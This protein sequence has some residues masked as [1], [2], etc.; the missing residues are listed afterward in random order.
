MSSTIASSTAL[1]TT[2][3]H[4]Q[5]LRNAI[6]HDMRLLQNQP[7]L[8]ANAQKALVE[9]ER[10]KDSIDYDL[11]WRAKHN[12]E[13]LLATYAEIPHQVSL[14]ISAAQTRLQ[15]LDDDDDY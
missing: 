3:R 9:I 6:C 1:T 8:I 14:S 12:I 11:Y 10:T 7:S 4:R 2:E 13:A 15:Q 5:V